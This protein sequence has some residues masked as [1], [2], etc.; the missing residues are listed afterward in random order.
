LRYWEKAGLVT[1]SRCPDNGYRM[2]NA[3]QQHKILLL[4]AMRTAVYSA[5]TVRLKQAIAELRDDDRRRMLETA[6]E[7]Q[8]YWDAAHLRQFRAAASICALIDRVS[9]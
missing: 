4:S 1:G 6:R 3:A 8:R 5:D 7:V 2:Y 9:H